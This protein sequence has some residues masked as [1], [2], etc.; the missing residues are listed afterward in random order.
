MRLFKAERN[1]KMRTAFV[2][3]YAAGLWVSEVDKL[4][5]GDIDRKRMVMH[6]RQAKGRK[7]IQFRWRRDSGT[8]STNWDVI[9][10]MSSFN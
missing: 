2:T 5:T 8:I 9:W 7:G 1:L 4:I 6:V 10:G 3:I